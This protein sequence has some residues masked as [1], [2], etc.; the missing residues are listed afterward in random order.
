[1]PRS[2]LQARLESV[3]QALASAQRIVGF[4]GAGISTESGIPDFR[5]P[6][7]T[8]TRDKVV[9]FDQF[10]SDA[11]ARKL[12]W[13]QKAKGWPEVR[14]AQPNSGHAAFTEL[15]TQ[16]RLRAMITQNIDGLHQL[17]G[18]P[19]DTVHEL[20]GTTREAECLSCGQRSSMD[21]AVERVLAGDEDPACETCGGIVKYATISF[22]QPMPQPVL[23]AAEQ[24]ARDCDF[25]LAVGSSLVVQP[26]ASLPV[27]AKHSGAKLLILNREETPL[28]EIAD[29]V[30]RGEIGA[31]L[32]ALVARDT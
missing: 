26:A 28:D 29:F 32:P 9:Y 4:T 15:H 14:D 11:E 23:K 30:I 2:D 17:A 7:G 5:S 10:L 22:G 31:V 13:R 27:V 3:H 8:W 25:F 21:A 24:A 18:L 12:A 20:H 1:M 6:N 16:G 19:A